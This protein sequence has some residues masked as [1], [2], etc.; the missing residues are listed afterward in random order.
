MAKRINDIFNNNTNIN[1]LF[2][3][4]SLIFDKNKLQVNNVTEKFLLFHIS[5]NFTFYIYKIRK[6]VQR[7]RQQGKKTSNMLADFYYERN[8]SFKYSTFHR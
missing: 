8:H 7:L 6:Q 4:I 3:V 5:Q 2:R 1:D